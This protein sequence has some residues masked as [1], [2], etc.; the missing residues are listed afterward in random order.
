MEV[1]LA[2]KVALITGGS[3]GIGLAI[4][5]AMAASGAAVMLTSRKQ[6][7]L[8]AAA[9]AIGDRAATYVANVGEIDAAGR[10]VQATIERFG[11]LDILLN[12]A[13]T[14]P[15][16]GPTL[17]AEPSKFDKTFSVN[18]K[19]PTRRLGRPADIASLAVFLVSEHASWITG[20]TY[21]VDGGAGVTIGATT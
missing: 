20:E 12:N 10:C 11:A 19:A 4:A 16:Y 3:K 8:S 1:S 14:N 18:L 7:Q 15:H 17:D 2:G 21:V 9:F 5:T 13:A 6:Q